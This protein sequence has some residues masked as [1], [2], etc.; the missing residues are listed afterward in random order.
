MN[1][2]G[3]EGNPMKITVSDGKTTASVEMMF[4][5]DVTPQMALACLI[6]VKKER[7]AERLCEEIEVT[8]EMVLSTAESP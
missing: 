4:P 1:A 7:E 5:P 8:A 2:R 6:H 3:P